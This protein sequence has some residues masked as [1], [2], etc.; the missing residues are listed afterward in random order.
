[1]CSFKVWTVF[2]LE[3]SMRTDT[4]WKQL[5]LAILFFFSIRNKM[6]GLQ[7]VSHRAIYTRN[8]CR[9]SRRILPFFSKIF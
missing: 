1:M 8:V 6:I 5:L 3:R 2:I 7:I 9:E 4:V